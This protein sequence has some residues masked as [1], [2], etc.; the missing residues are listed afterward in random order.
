MNEKKHRAWIICGLGFLLVVALVPRFV[1]PWKAGDKD[2]CYLNLKQ[3]DG[4][5]QLWADEHHK[6]TNAVPT[7][8]DLNPYLKGKPYACPNGGTYTLL[9]AAEGPQCSIMRHNLEYGTV[10]VFETN[11]V[12]LPEAKVSI[13][14]RTEILKS[15]VTESDGWVRTDL[16]Y[17]PSSE[18]PLRIV[19]SKEGYRDETSSIEVH[20]P[21][22]LQLKRKEGEK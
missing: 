4:A 3:M 8:G 14:K 13:Y 17:Y 19:V 2:N 11:G 18:G 5:M 7:W 1:P 12:A 16:R 10:Y 22:R 21:I 9:T 6:P 15:Y 20:W